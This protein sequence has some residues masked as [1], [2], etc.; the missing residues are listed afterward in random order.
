MPIEEVQPAKPA[1]R[2][3]LRAMRI[4][5]KRGLRRVY[6]VLCVVWAIWVLYYPYKDRARSFSSDYSLCSIY[7][8]GDK[9]YDS[10]GHQII[11]DE[12]EDT[13]YI[14]NDK[15]LPGKVKGR[16]PIAKTVSAK[17]R[18][19]RCTD[20]VSAKYYPK[21]KNAYQVLLTDEPLYNGDK[22]GAS[23]WA[24][25][26]VPLAVILPPAFLYALIIAVAQFTRWIYQGFFPAT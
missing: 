6:F 17:E 13:T 23:W 2:H 15:G 14:W 8:T 4:T 16:I 1:P 3:W 26:L 12:S 11:Y 19:R 9:Y 21:G 22:K 20:D 5:V 10:A 24:W 25:L 18:F 7:G